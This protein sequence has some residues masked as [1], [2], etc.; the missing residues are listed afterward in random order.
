MLK[1]LSGFEN[2]TDSFDHRIKGNLMG[3]PHNKNRYGE[4]WP[5]HRIDVSLQELESIKP[6][7]VV[8]GGWAW[9]F[10]S[11]KGH[12]EFKHAHDHKDID[13]FV[14]PENVATV[15][16]ILKGRAFE[17]VWTKYDK[18]PSKVDFRRYEKRVALAD[19]TSVKITIDFFVSSEVSYRV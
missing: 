15:V 16:S 6:F 5:Q 19:G 10:M 14:A 9:H 3:D 2:L 11:P 7:I 13:L 17:K 12:V 18:L 8:S 4:V 1:E